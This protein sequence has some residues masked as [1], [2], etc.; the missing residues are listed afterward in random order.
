[1]YWWSFFNPDVEDQILCSQKEERHIKFK[2]I[3]RKKKKKKSFKDRLSKNFFEWCESPASGGGLQTVIFFFSS[4]LL[5]LFLYFSIMKSL[6][7]Q[8]HSNP[9]SLSRLIICAANIRRIQY[10]VKRRPDLFPEK[11]E[12]PPRFCETSGRTDCL[13]K[14][15]RWLA[16]LCDWLGKWNKNCTQAWV[17]RKRVKKR[18]ERVKL[19]GAEDQK[20][21]SKSPIR[22]IRYQQRWKRN[23]LQNPFPFLISARD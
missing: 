17:G 20:C 22:Q 4:T 10:H 15:E 9:I 12:N 3:Y 5:Y 21:Q 2:K 16:C 18:E 1:M 11:K 23:F 8:G 19:A 14:T 13:K 7:G 6:T